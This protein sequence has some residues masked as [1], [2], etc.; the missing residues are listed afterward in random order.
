MNHKLVQEF[1]TK[2]LSAGKAPNSGKPELSPVA[3]LTKVFAAAARK[4]GP[5]SKAAIVRGCG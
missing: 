1:L 2:K 4:R 3:K 5:M